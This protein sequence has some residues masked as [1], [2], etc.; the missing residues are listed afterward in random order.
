MTHS[1]L[2]AEP[3]NPI[4]S[5]AAGFIYLVRYPQYEQQPAFAHPFWAL[6]S[7]WA[8]TWILRTD[9]IPLVWFEAQL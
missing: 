3:V 9:S 6:G 2:V 7:A 1:D 8:D 5:K 4:I